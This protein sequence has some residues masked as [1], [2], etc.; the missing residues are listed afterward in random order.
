MPFC[1]HFLDQN[2][3]EMIDCVHDELIKRSFTTSVAESCTGGFLS[4]CLTSCSGASSY[5]KGSVV[6]YSN[7]LKIGFLDIDE[8][9]INEHGVASQIIVELM[10]ENIRKKFNT[11]FGLATTGYVDG[12]SRPLPNQKKDMQNYAWI[13]ISTDKSVYSKRLVLD[14][15]RLNNIAIISLA[16][17]ELLRKEIL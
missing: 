10:A 6:V 12:F 2:L 11:N 4:S 14:D 1:S 8:K 16:V 7:E 15:D 13:G 17:L 5:F 9:D 3:R